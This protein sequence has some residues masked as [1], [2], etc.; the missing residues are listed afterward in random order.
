MAAA[1]RGLERTRCPTGGVLARPHADMDI[2]QECWQDTK[3]Q[4]WRILMLVWQGGN[5]HMDFGH[6]LSNKG[7]F[8]HACAKTCAVGVIRR[9]ILDKVYV[10]KKESCSAHN[11]CQLVLADKCDPVPV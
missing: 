2:C 3:D 8:Y 1:L 9:M 4:R 11:K 5:L 10:S 7:I 6:H